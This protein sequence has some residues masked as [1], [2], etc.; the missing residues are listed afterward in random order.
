MQML[1]YNM[2]LIPVDKCLDLV[3]QFEPGLFQFPAIGYVEL[4]LFQTIFR[5]PWVWNSGVKLYLFLVALDKVKKN[6][7]ASKQQRTSVDGPAEQPTG[8]SCSFP[9][10]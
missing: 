5:L 1:G 2:G 3:I 6:K 9:Y 10:L 7:E 8:D 4:M